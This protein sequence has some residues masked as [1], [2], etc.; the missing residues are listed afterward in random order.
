MSGLLL[1]VTHDKFSAH[2]FLFPGI[3]ASVVVRMTPF[4]RKTVNG[5]LSQIEILTSAR[6]WIGIESNL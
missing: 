2:V 6:I 1:L 4:R 3:T 5:K